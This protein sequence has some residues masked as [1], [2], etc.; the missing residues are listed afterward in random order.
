MRELTQEFWDRLDETPQ[1]RGG[2]FVVSFGPAEFRSGLVPRFPRLE[3][4]RK[5]L[6][7]ITRRL[8]MEERRL[9]ME[10]RL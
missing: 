9:E 4:R 6:A 3:R 8:E 5:Q 2:G 1:R 7:E 10:E